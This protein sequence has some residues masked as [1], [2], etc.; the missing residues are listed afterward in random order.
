M[1]CR[2]HLHLP[3][4][5]ILHPSPLQTSHLHSSPSASLL[6]CHLSIPWPHWPILISLCLV[7]NL[8]HPAKRA[9]AR[10]TATICTKSISAW[11]YWASGPIYKNHSAHS[12]HHSKTPAK[13]DC[14]QCCTWLPSRLSRWWSTCCG[15]PFVWTLFLSGLTWPLRHT[16]HR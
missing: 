7:H 12:S 16:Q 4:R 5:S 1:S 2:I 13:S 14:T 9:K 11:L 10:D 6:L 15:L 8:A 3:H